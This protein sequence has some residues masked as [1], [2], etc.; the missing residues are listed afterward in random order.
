MTYNPWYYNNNNGELVKKRKPCLP[1]DQVHT[2]S[3]D[4][5][6][7]VHDVKLDYFTIVKN[8]EYKK[9]PWNC[10]IC[11]KGNGMSTEAQ[12]KVKLRNAIEYTNSLNK[13]LVSMVQ[14]LK[15]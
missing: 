8:R 7:T 9:I 13:T 11:L 14:I 4:G 10:F 2:K 5:C 6:F 12:L 15:F 1:G 3:F